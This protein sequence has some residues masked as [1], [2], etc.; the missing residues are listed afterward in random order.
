[1]LF[2]DGFTDLKSDKFNDIKE[3]KLIKNVNRY[4]K[5]DFCFI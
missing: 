5:I 2:Y 4:G 1:M 3:N